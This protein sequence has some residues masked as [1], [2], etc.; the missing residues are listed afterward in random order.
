MQRATCV[1]LANNAHSNY[2]RLFFGLNFEH[3]TAIVRAAFRANDMRLL[4]FT[5]VFAGNEVIQGQFIM[6]TTIELASSRQF[7]L[8]QRTHDQTP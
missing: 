2:L 8:W 4:V 1:A 7:A 3:L 6:I 5:A